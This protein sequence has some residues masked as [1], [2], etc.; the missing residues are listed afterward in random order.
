MVKKMENISTQFLMHNHKVSNPLVEHLIIRSF[1]YSLFGLNFSVFGIVFSS[2]K[3]YC[4]V[5]LLSFLGFLLSDFCP[6]A[7]VILV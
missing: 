6:V 1:C 2:A 7:S 3:V 5:F 4:S